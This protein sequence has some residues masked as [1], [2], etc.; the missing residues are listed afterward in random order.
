VWSP[1]S[2][3]DPKQIPDDKKIKILKKGKHVHTG[4]FGNEGSGGQSYL[5]YN[6]KAGNT[7]KFLLHGQPTGNDHTVYTAYFFAPELN[8]WVLI[9][10]FSRPATTTW[11]T[12]LHSFLENFDP[13]T[14]H[15]SRKAFYQNQWIKAKNGNWKA[16]SK[17]TFTA[18]TTANKGYRLDY[19]GGEESGRF[20][21]RNCG[22]FNDNTVLKTKFEH[23]VPV[24]PPVIDFSVLE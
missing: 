13:S 15:I 8:K 11:L 10:S 19:A 1:F 9:A 20:F 6:W 18:D 14:G 4:E 21:L 16:I 7:Y 2:T 5:K 23:A 3:D 12:R 24:Q 22:F 17:V